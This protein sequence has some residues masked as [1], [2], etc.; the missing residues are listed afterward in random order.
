MSKLLIIFFVSFLSIDCLLKDQINL[1]LSQG[2]IQTETVGKK[3]TVIVSFEQRGEIIEF[4]N[5]RKEECFKS[6]IF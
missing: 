6:K 3:G 5:T 4:K 2:Y 1:Q